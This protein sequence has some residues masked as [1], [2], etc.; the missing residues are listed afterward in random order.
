MNLVSKRHPFITPL[1]HIAKT[2]AAHHALKPDQLGPT[3]EIPILGSGVFGVSTGPL[4]R[5]LR[6]GAG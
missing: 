6:F 4:A 2:P 3:F 5:P 1:K